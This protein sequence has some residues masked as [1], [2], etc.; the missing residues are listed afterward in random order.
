M[1]KSITMKDRLISEKIN[2]KLEENILNSCKKKV[3]HT[4]IMCR[5]LISLIKEKNKIQ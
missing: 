5:F 4:Q 2:S 3:N 1:L